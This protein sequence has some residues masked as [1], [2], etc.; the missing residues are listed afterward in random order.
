MATHSSVLAWRIPGMGAWWAAIYG[1]AQS[2]TRLKWLSSSSASKRA[3]GPGKEGQGTGKRPSTHCPQV[4]RSLNSFEPPVSSLV[5][6]VD[7]KVARD[8]RC[9]VTHGKWWPPLPTFL[10]PRCSLLGGSPLNPRCHPTGNPQ[11]HSC[12]LSTSGATDPLMPLA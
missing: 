5:R 11:V 1:V 7:G 8:H 6:W 2:R 12:V 10:C 4:G 3:C 9:Q